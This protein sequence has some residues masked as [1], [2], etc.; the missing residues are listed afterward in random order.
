MDAYR[1]KNGA[2]NSLTCQQIEYA[3]KEYRGHRKIP[4]RILD[5]GIFPNKNSRT[6]LHLRTFSKSTCT[7]L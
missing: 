4:L 1:I 2:G 5:I 7:I 6:F 3:V